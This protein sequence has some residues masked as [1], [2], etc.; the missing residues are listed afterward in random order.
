MKFPGALLKIKMNFHNFY[1]RN[2]Q[3]V[4]TFSGS[5]HLRIQISRTNISQKID[6]ENQINQFSKN[7]LPRFNHFIPLFKHN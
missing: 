3:N 6:G 4:T 1:F 2:F 7:H 5:H